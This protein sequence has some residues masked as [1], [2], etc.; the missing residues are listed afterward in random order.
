MP[1]KVIIISRILPRLTRL[2]G[3]KHSLA[4]LH[5]LIESV[6]TQVNGPFDVRDIC[7]AETS[8]EG[9]A[10]A[11]GEPRNARDWLMEFELHLTEWRNRGKPQ[12]N[13]PLI[14]RIIDPAIMRLQSGQPIDTQ[15]G[16]LWKLWWNFLDGHP[17]RQV[18]WSAFQER[19]RRQGVS[20]TVL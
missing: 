15:H 14:D 7:I 4:F 12:A 16:P 3:H 11:E 17:D 9:H 20:E 5:A 1:A 8:I 10:W 18:A 13:D 2:S 6:N 19:R